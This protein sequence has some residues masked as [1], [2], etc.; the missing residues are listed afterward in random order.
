MKWILKQWAPE[1]Y[2]GFMGG[3]EAREV[4][5]VEGELWYREPPG[6]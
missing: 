1:M 4:R 5:R 3:T 6:K 2:E